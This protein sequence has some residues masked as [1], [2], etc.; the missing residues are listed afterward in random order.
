VRRVLQ[1]IRRFRGNGPRPMILAYHRIASPPLDPWGLAVHPDRFDAQLDV[2]RSKRVVMRVSEMVNRLQTGTLPDKAVGI[3]FDDGYVDNL[4][5]AQPRLAVQSMP[6]TLFLTAGAIGPGREFWWDELARA[7]LGRTDPFDGEVRIDGR[8]MRVTVDG[9]PSGDSTWRAWQE[10]RT[11]QQQAYLGLWRLLSALDI[12]ER[13]ASMRRLRESLRPEPP[14]PADVPMTSADVECVVR[15]GLFEIGGH[16]VTHPMLPR[17]DPERRRSEIADGKSRCE[18]FAH[19]PIT[20]F[21]YPH[22]AEDA[23]CRAAVRD[24][25]FHWACTTAGVPVSAD[26]D[27][28]ALPRLCVPDVDRDEFARIVA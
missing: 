24:C 14:N 15:G 23:D 28:F 6:A 3:T 1:R 18:E 4:V 11:S 22:G 2:L 17:L 5:E 12:V 13:D 9:P 26:C 27:V 21:A 16:T 7:I 10:P 8:S 19:R 25:G 20:G